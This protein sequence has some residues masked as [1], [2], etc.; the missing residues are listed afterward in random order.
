MRLVDPVDIY[1]QATRATKYGVLFVVLTFGAFW[2]FEALRG[3]PIHPMQYGFV[4]TALAIFFLLL[5]ALSEHLPFAAAY[6][7]AAVAC[8]LLVTA[9]LSPV[10]GGRRAAAGF[11]A[12]FAA[13]HGV[14]YSVLQLEDTALLC[15][16]LLMF[17]AL[18]A[19]MLASRRIDWTRFGLPAPT[20]RDPGRPSR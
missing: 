9:Y 15:G 2:L 7:T 8:V 19:A 20:V 16:T 14:L 6:A 17:S 18:A 4:G 5:L 13:L 12:G 10:L 1:A 11:G 3:V